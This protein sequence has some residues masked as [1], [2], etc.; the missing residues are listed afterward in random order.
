MVGIPQISVRCVLSVSLSIRAPGWG[1]GVG[2]QGET[3][4]MWRW[5]RGGISVIK[6]F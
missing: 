5:G 4:G 6:I 1:C 2:G 3:G